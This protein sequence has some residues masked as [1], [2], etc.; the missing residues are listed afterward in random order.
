MS[1][2]M[3]PVAVVVHVSGGS[4]QRDD[5]SVC[6]VTDCG[7]E[8]HKIGQ[9]LVQ[10]PNL[11]HLRMDM[12]MRNDVTLCALCDIMHVAVRCETL[13]FTQAST[14]GSGRLERT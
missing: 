9:V 13:W 8:L 11:Q 10:L 14:H 3:L 12:S 4:P 7:T 1:A 2:A 5:P 6:I